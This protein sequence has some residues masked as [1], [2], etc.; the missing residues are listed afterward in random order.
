MSKVNRMMLSIRQEAT[1][2]EISPGI[3][4]I[5]LFRILLFLK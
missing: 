1:E 4:V 5:H 2:S 3:S